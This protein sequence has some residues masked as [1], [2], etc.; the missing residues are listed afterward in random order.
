[1][2]LLLS[3]K[4]MTRKSDER[5]R[6]TPRAAAVSSDPFRKR[7]GRAPMAGAY[8]K[9]Q[10]CGDLVYGT[11]C[12]RAMR[13]NAGKLKE[14]SHEHVPARR[15]S[16]DRAN[17]VLRSIVAHFSDWPGR[18]I[19]RSHLNK[20]GRDPACYPGFTYHTSYP[21]PGAIRRY[22]ASTTVHAWYDLVVSR[23]NFRA[24]NIAQRGAKPA[25]PT[26]RRAAK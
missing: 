25:N 17:E 11:L 6:A 2:A 9:H 21:E 14:V 18:Y 22:I 13:Y 5:I 4:F 10:L 16:P 1:M 24:P 26:D 23:A 3:A 8:E 7:S 12:F 20:R 19:V 15:I